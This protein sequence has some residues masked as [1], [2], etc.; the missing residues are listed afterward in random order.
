[1]GLYKRENVWWMSFTHK[2][3]RF[4][5]SAETTDRRTAEKI[6][7]QVLDEI[8]S[9]KWDLP[10]EEVRTFGMLVDTYLED[11]S[12]PTKTEKSHRRDAGILRRIR[13]DLG[14]E[15]PL[16]FIDVNSVRNWQKRRRGTEVAPATLNKEVSLLSRLFTLAITWGWVERNP[17]ESLP[18]DKVQN[19]KERWLT[20]DEEERLLDCCSERLASLVVFALN[21]GFRRGE[22]L[23]LTWDQVDM[24]RR[25]IT[26]W[27]QKNGGRDTVPLNDRA[28]EVLSDLHGIRSI[29]SSCVFL[30]ANGTPFSERNI[31]RDFDRAVKKSGIPRL[32]FHDLRH[33][34]ATR[35][36]HAGVDLYTVQRLGR[37]R[38]LSMVMRYAHHSVESLRAGM[39]AVSRIQNFEKSSKDKDLKILSQFLSQS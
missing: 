37:W 26:F 5:K 12:K 15:T 9:G 29:S 36:V 28:F 23:A 11:H 35:L 6:Y 24:Q 14:S 18:R 25:T 3:E 8:A 4:R 30:T 2:G 32:R 10:P 38:T 13:E 1:M 7:L 19:T 21:T 31:T 22:I 27:K 17:C 39:D 34:F 33:T 20:S 16:S